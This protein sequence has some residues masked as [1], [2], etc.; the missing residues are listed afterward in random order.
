MSERTSNLGLLKKD[1][2][3]DRLDTFSVGEMLNGNWDRI[4]E[5]YEN[6]QKRIDLNENF[7]NEIE[8]KVLIKKN[9]VVDI[10]SNTEKVMS[11]ETVLLR[12]VAVFNPKEST[13]GTIK[14]TIPKD[15]G[16]SML[17]IKISGFEDF[18]DKGTWDIEISAY[19]YVNDW[20]VRGIVVNGNPRFSE[21]RLGYDSVR[22]R[23]AILLGQTSTTLA[24][25][26]IWIDNVMIS[27]SN[28]HDWEK[29][30]NI[31]TISDETGIEKI[32]EP[33]IQQNF[34]I[35]NYGNRIQENSSF[36][37]SLKHS[38]SFVIVNGS[39][40]LTNI[41]IEKENSIPIGSQ[42]TILRYSENDIVFVAG[43]GVSLIS[44]E[45][46]RKIDGRYS[47]AT[48]VKSSST[49]WYIIG[50]LTN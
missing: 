35:K 12:N 15:K 19:Y 5:Y 2:V 14:I 50:A 41:T 33:D 40:N 6:T 8:G 32:V 38:N 3:V 29:G 23:G 18:K 47:A 42:I 21:V 37:V 13:V 24:R 11:N 36:I 20:I 30:W 43:D 45:N 46:N 17:K 39:G 26:K 27:H 31:E 44:K 1:P 10:G 25:P 28:I 16:N 4:D 34:N 9:G 7:R 49:V 22:K 48:L